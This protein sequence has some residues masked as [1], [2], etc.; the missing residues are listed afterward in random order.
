[1][2][3]KRDPKYPTQPAPTNEVLPK[4]PI[5]PGG[6]RHQQAKGRD[7]GL[8]TSQGGPVATNQNLATAGKRGP[9]LLQDH[10]FRDKI[11]HFDH[12]RI[13]ERVVHAR[14]SGAHGVFET[15]ESLEDITCADIFARAGEKTEVF[16]RFSTVAGNKGSFDLARDVR[17][18][19]VKFYTQEGN[20]DLVGNNI[21]VFFIQDAFKF[22][23]L[24][25]AVKEAPDRG[26]P[27]AQSAHDNFWDFVSLMPESTH[28]LL[29]AMSDRGIPRSFRFMEGFGVH[30]YKFVNAKGEA[31]FVKFHWK[32][33]Q[34]LQSVT[35]P[36]A[37]SIN[38]ADPDFHR[39]DL[40]DSIQAGDFPEWELGVQVFDDEFADSFDFDVLD[41][42]K[43][44]PEE[45]VP[46]RPIGKMTLNRTVASH[47]DETE[48]VAFMTQNIVRGID[49]S[50]D[51]LLQGRNF[52]Y[53][54]TQLKRLGSTNFTQLP[55]NSP[56]CP[57]AN[58]HR[59]GHMQTDLHTGR[60]SYEPNSWTGDERGPRESEE[61]GLRFEQQEVSGAKHQARAES[62][63]DHYSQAHQ[64]WISQTEVE[65]QHIVAAF[66]FELS[67]C[68]VP[69]IR[70]RMLGNLRNVDE[71]LAQRVADGLGMELPGASKPAVAPRKGLPA[72]DALSILKNGPKDFKGRKL[73]L[74]V[75]EKTDA[76]ALKALVDAV[77]GAGGMVDV[78]TPTVGGA[79]LSDGS[80][81][82][83]AQ[84]IKGTKAALY[85]AVA[86]LVTEQAAEELADLPEARDFVT[87]AHVNCKFVGWNPEAKP[88]AVASGVAPD[89]G[90]VDLADAKAAVKAFG[91]LR[92][93]ERDVTAP[94]K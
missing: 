46:V 48:Q 76:D 10:V 80:Q 66:T 5:A 18:F 22:P 2:A 54:D 81:Q 24:V 11:F 34:G 17:G 70:T 28:M 16:V 78:I 63:A 4:D 53:L 59:D 77:I 33:L 37:L 32:P 21:P 89:K 39:R 29:W 62:F 6:E 69:Q 74:V 68:E 20:W 87:E 44:I 25:H 88:L 58:F 51:P 23:D 7:D 57:V 85:D 43:L 30:S 47:F 93:W 3:S 72:S 55:V 42:T 73:G 83:G 50:D 60:A 90:W 9:A 31:R 45:L 26:F 91:K 71:A 79:K 65:Q 84:F 56:R 64:F 8:T 12:E 92:F 67:K 86:L 14:G 35:W 40:W 19:A 49:F 13:P 36:E 52:S 94:A 38:G 82:P 27:Q 1:M 41:P 15:Y 75:G 61:L